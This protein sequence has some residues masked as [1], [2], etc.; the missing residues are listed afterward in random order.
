MA[1]QAWLTLGVVVVVLGFLIRG[2]TSP[3]LV[4]LGAT[5]FLLAVG[6]IDTSQALAGF[7]NPAPFTVAA[8]YVVAAAVQKTGAL[9]PI[10]HGTMGKRKGIR[11][12]LGRLALPVAGASAFLNNTPI[13]AMLIPQVQSWSSKYKISVSKFLMPLSFATILG[14]TVTVIGTSTNLVVSGL[15]SDAGLGELGFIEI[16]KVGLPIAVIGIVFAVLITPYV[17]PSRKGVKEELYGEARKFSAELV[18]VAKGP[19]DGKTVDQAGLR[20]LPGVFLTSL[21]RV[22]GPVIAPV[23]PDTQL[24]AGDRLRFAGQAQKVLDMQEVRGLQSAEL[25]HFADLDDPGVSYYEAVIGT[26]SPLVGQTLRGAGFRGNYQAAVVAIHRDGELVD[27]QLGRV[28]LRVGDTLILV[29]DSGFKNRWANREDFLLIS[30]MDDIAPITSTPKAWLP[31]TVIAVIV[32]LAA[33]N[34]VP[35]LIG[36]LVGSV[37]LVGARVLSVSEAQR[38]IDFEVIVIIAAAFGIASAME[39][40]GLAQHAASS[41]VSITEALGERGALLGIVL[42]TVV[43]T[44]MITNNAAA[45]L[46]FPIAI[47]IAAETGLNPVGVAIAIAIAASASFLTPIGYQT[48]TMIYGPGGYR[49]GDYVRLGFP[50][51]ILVIGMIVWLVPI[52]WPSGV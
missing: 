44:E 9:A 13:M 2:R 27:A 17:L 25:E 29:A 24:R 16:G 19:I 43:L 42:A 18:V 20:D 51:T 52:M 35:I 45:L 32:V 4:V 11:R 22:T 5:I 30:P 37:V 34:L 47:T 48:N 10:L 23:T 21:T 40:T 28:Q 46:M 38:S 8:L 6:V 36:A 3:A 31:I 33:F 49:F 26:R 39:T 14:G 12:P 15:M 41:I 7:S 1:W 50:L